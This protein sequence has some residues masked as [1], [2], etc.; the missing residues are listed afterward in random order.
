MTRRT[1][2]T[3][4]FAVANL[5][6]ISTVGA[7]AVMLAPAVSPDQSVAQATVMPPG[8]PAGFNAAI[9]SDTQ[10][11]AYG[12]LAGNTLDGRSP[13]AVLQAPHVP[14]LGPRIIPRG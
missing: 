7:Q 6:L 10:L 8:P 1:F 4:V 11:A 5:P 2:A 12:F 14:Q 13:S 3:L 9:A